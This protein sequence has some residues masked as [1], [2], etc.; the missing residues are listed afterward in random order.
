MESTTITP[1]LTSFL[2][3]KN[4]TFNAIEKLL[5][6][7]TNN[8][9][10]IECLTANIQ[11]IIDSVNEMKQY[12]NMSEHYMLQYERC[13]F[14]ISELNWLL[15]QKFGKPVKCYNF[16]DTSILPENG[17]LYELV[18]T[19]CY[20]SHP[21]N[22]LMHQ[23]KNDEPP[24]I[25]DF[26]TWIITFNTTTEHWWIKFMNE[27]NYPIFNVNTLSHLQNDLIQ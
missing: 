26:I 17:I 9:L 20:H 3:Y 7:L 8:E 10:T 1:A 15:T 25:N 24:T 16:T 4:N 5:P 27:Y 22:R 14:S 23:C 21:M 6:Y 2:N 18:N 12:S 19:L 11:P 13:V